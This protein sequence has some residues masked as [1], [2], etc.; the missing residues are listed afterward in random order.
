MLTVDALLT[1]AKLRGMPGS[2]LRGVLREYLQVLLLKELY[3]L[4]EGKEFYFTGGTYLR[5]LHGT[6]RFSEDLDF[7]AQQLTQNTFEAILEK[8]AKKLN[9]EGFDCVVEFSHWGKI[10]VANILFTA[11]EKF[12]G[13][14]SKYS[15]KEGL[16]IKFEVN[17]PLWSIKP[18][19]LVISG[20]G[21]MYP[22]L[23][24]QKG[25]LMADKIDAILS[26]HRARHIFD[27]IFMLSQNYP[28]D[29]AVLKVLA[30]TEDPMKLLKK[31]IDGFS[32][33][34]LKEF[35][36]SLRP[37]LFEESEAEMIVNAKTIIPQLI[38]KYQ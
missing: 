9:K 28:I 27:I 25:A 15:K 1:E 8:L 31:R 37:F 11:I 26:K 7:N 12:Y 16:S 34:E 6:R 22:A 2:K 21:Q 14:N 38:A 18:E 24:T 23:C 19:T 30:I 5:L 13:V 4:P 3:S 33:K 17:R 20:F 29:K 36:E 35:A 32:S 10:L